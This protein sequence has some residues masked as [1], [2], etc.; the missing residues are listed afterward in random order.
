MTNHSA[1][2]IGHYLSALFTFQHLCEQSS[3]CVRVVNANVYST[4]HT[5]HTSIKS[6]CVNAYVVD[7]MVQTTRRQMYNKLSS[8]LN[9]AQPSAK[10]HCADKNAVIYAYS[11]ICIIL[12]HNKMHILWQ[13]IKKNT[14]NYT[15]KVLNKE[16]DYTV[17]MQRYTTIVN[18]Y[19]LGVLLAQEQPENYKNI[20]ANYASM[21]VLI[22]VQR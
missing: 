1:A 18:V 7:G 3:L 19:R 16:I 10:Q 22:A 4:F 8:P 13:I 12:I 5:V 2:I 6:N 11:C 21:N 17:H 15:K 20:C 14:V 9:Y